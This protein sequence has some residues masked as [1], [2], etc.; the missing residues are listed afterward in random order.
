[1]RQNQS[2]I[3]RFIRFLAV[4]RWKTATSLSDSEQF[5]IQAFLRG[6]GPRLWKFQQKWTQANWF[7]REFV[8]AKQNAY[9]LRWRWM[10]GN[11]FHASLSEC[12]A[13]AP[14]LFDDATKGCPLKFTL[15]VQPH[16]FCG[17]LIG[18]TVDGS[19]WPL[20]WEIPEAA[21]LRIQ[22]TSGLL[23]LPALAD[24]SAGL[25]R[26]EAWLGSPIDRRFVYLIET[27]EGAALEDLQTLS[28][29]GEYA[30]LLS[31]SNGLLIGETYI[32]PA[33]NLEVLEI[34]S[35]QV[36]LNIADDL[37]NGLADGFYGYHMGINKPKG[38]THFGMYGEETPAAASLKEFILKQIAELAKSFVPAI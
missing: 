18:E 26:L 22:E 9:S 21:R 15:H 38:L 8:D 16:G 27:C 12:L 14:I 20:H 30:D 29:P 2:L 25:E 24:Q 23:P 36:L 11:F 32:K 1:M 5:L 19:L 6:K 28:L 7:T 35:D 17:P 33:S 31:V 4:Q 34:S 10:A 37:I 3:Q 13:S